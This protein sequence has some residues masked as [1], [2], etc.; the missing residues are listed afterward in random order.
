V[1]NVEVAIKGLLG[2]CNALG[3]EGGEAGP[4]NTT[5]EALDIG[6]HSVHAPQVGGWG[7]MCERVGVWT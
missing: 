2:I 5:L 3:A 6:A 7:D 4:C 1:S